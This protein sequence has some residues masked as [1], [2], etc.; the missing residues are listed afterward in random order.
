MLQS[1]G[2]AQ[3]TGILKFCAAEYADKG[4]MEQYCLRVKLKGMSRF[5]K[6]AFRPCMTGAVFH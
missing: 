6:N 3:L 5:L 4:C 2:A 1:A